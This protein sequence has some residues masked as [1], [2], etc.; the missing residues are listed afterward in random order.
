M[1]PNQDKGLP[2]D[3][4]AEESLSMIELEMETE[5]NDWDAVHNNKCANMKPFCFSDDIEFQA[6]SSSDRA[7]DEGGYYNCLYSTP[8]PSWFYMKIQ[9]GGALKFTMKGKYDIDFIVWGPYDSLTH[10]KNSCTSG[11]S[12]N[13][14]L[15]CSY[16][17]GAKEYGKITVD[18]GKVYVLLITNF[19]NR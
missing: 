6:Y 11:M 5:G 10:A 7:S 13:N 1:C 8:G 16:S 19:A 3:F 17:S 15:D 12:R 2:G 9:N 18:T 14:W 4:I